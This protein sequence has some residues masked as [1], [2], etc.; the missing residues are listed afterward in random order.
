MKEKIISWLQLGRMHTFPA[1]WL[2]VI[3]PFLHG[4]SNLF[5]ALILTIFMWFVHFASFS[6]NSLFDFTQGYDR[7]DPAKSS[8][9]LEQGTI[10]VHS[11]VNVIVWAK[12]LLMVVGALATIAWSPSP[13]W[14]MVALF[15]WYT[16]GTAYNIG[17]SKESLFGFIP[18]SVCFTSMG[19]W[20]WLLSHS[21]LGVLG[22]LYLAF[23]FF[24]I[25][26]Q[27]SWSGHLKEMGQE[28]RSNILIKMGAELKPMWTKEEVKSLE[29]VEPSYAKAVDG[30]TEFIPGKAKI[31]GGTIKIINLYLALMLFLVQVSEGI[32]RIDMPLYWFSIVAIAV[33]SFTATIFLEKLVKQRIYHRPTELKN[34]GIEEIATIFLP[35]PVLMGF[36]SIPF[37]AA[38][39]IYYFGMNRWLWQASYPKV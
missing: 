39:A 28:E 27:I 38:A 21:E 13:L 30:V 9:P 23:V 2:L 3:V 31:Y 8:H 4:H 35:M 20:A 18:I 37:M 1:D 34:M 15:M 29:G 11:A 32:L 26:F 16:W 5:Q 17:L 36:L 19:S 25:L 33:L 14:S 7:S 6:E 12:A 10:S 22:T 24:T